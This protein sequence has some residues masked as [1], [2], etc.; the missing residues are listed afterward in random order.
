MKVLVTGGAG[1]IGSHLVNRLVR[2]GC[3]VA[4]VDNLSAGSR[5]F[6][7][8]KA[9]F[10][11]VDIRD[12]EGLKAAI[13]KIQPEIIVHLAA[14]IDVVK[15]FEDPSF[16]ASVNVFGTL[17][18]LK[19]SALSG[20]R[21]FV[22]TSSAAVYGEP[23]KLPVD[24]NHR[25]SP[26]SPYGVSKASG[27]WFTRIYCEKS[28][29]EWVVFRLAN[30]YGPRQGVYSKGGVISMMIESFLK[31]KE[32]TLYSP[33]YSSRD[34]IYVDDV[35]EAFTRAINSSSSGIFN[36]S[37]NR[38]TYLEELYETVTKY[39]NGR[40]K[41]E[42]MIREG[43]IKRIYLDNTKAREVLAWEPAVDLEEGVYRT[44]EFWKE[45]YR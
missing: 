5:E 26:L 13:E 9:E 32:F 45:K 11:E 28:G 27:E 10:F 19:L 25:L 41:I 14:Q 15:S 30:V 43:E 7:N 18:L 29:I 23:K 8:S 36:I 4:V 34:F 17:N 33:A 22:F 35:V 44:L 42:S 3:K 6:V 16:D 20:I 24:E 12:Y 31:G 21:K 39:L 2:E 40:V 38:E 1:F 37:S